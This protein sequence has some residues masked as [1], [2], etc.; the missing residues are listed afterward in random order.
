MVES[1]PEH[2]FIEFELI[3]DIIPPFLAE[4]IL[5]FADDL[6]TSIFLDNLADIID[7][8]IERIHLLTDEP[9]FLEVPV[10]YFPCMP[11][12]DRLIL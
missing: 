9:I 4:L 5:I 8:A 2:F 11:L 12:V 7:E 6:K 3:Y 1:M 10:D